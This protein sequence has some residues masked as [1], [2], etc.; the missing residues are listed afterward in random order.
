[1]VRRAEA[2]RVC[3]WLATSESVAT[4]ATIL[5]GD[6]RIGSGDGREVRLGENLFVHLVPATPDNG[7][8]GSDEVLGY[9]LELR[10]R[11][12]GGAEVETLESLGLL[13]GPESIALPGLPLPSFFL[14]GHG[15]TLHVLHGSCRLLHGGGEDAFIAAQEVLA[16][17]ASDIEQRP[18]AMFLTGDQIYADDVAGPMI[19]HVRE[20]ARSLVGVGDSS[21]VPGVP[22][23]D[24]IALEGRAAIVT[25]AAKFTS[26]KAGNHLMSFGEFAAMYVLAWN[27]AAWPQ[28]FTPA[29]DALP[30]SGGSRSAVARA[31]R[32]Y[33]IQTDNLE[34]ARAALPAV[35]RVLANTPTYMIFDDH[36][37]TDDWNLTEAWKASVRRS[38]TG[39]RIVSNALA[40]YWAFQAW[41]ND[42]DSYDSAFVEAIVGHVA[43]EPGADDERFDSAL[44]DFPRW[45]YRA[46]T[47]PPTVVLDTRMHRHYD[48]PEGGARLVESEQL[49]RAA[50]LAR[51]GGHRPGRPLIIVSA[52]P[53]FGFE[54]QERRQKFLVDKLG[55][56]EIDFEAWHSNLRGLV[57]FM[58]LLIEDLRPAPCVLLSGD[59]HYGVNAQAFFAIGDD[60]VSVTQLVS[61]GFKH[62]GVLAKTALD[63]VGRLLRPKHERVGWDAPPE[64]KAPALVGMRIVS[65]PVNTDE[66]ADDSP[67]FL[68]PRDVKVL[69]IKTP[70]DYRECRIYVKP[71]GRNRSILVGENNVGLVSLDG[72][73]VVH[74]LLARGRNR[75]SEHKARVSPISSEGARG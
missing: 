7:A 22:S 3:L 43:G 29:E 9:D 24:D 18:G 31:R 10:R 70:P 62:A 67:V 75:T 16:R 2:A 14:R 51:D 37:V 59:V 25:D 21:S 74:R 13:D 69:R 6:T 46:P 20:L 60:E 4:R 8:F 33:R 32:R 55:P 34:R 42:P 41:G 5:L 73:E 40:S 23:L 50:R 30:A 71:E 1:M 15:P 36:D 47:D 17:T 65:R 49:R 66:W 28:S 61:S 19:L 68:A 12:G 53:V 52:V 56:Y 57:D 27:G 72:A 38:P 11:A 45:S 54:M 58:R 26:D 63:S 64:H 39:R 35:R 48:A 44:W